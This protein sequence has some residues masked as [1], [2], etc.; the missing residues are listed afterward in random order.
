M[1]SMDGKKAREAKGRRRKRV[2]INYS[3][4]PCSRV[5]TRNLYITGKWI[6]SSF[7]T[8]R[9]SNLELEN[10]LLTILAYMSINKNLL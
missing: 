3:A 2:T 4:I 5:Y 1:A 6:F 8:N 9:F 10:V 7:S